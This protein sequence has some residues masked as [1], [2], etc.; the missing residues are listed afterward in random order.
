[1]RLALLLLAALLA[2]SAAGAAAEAGTDPLG[3]LLQL[4]ARRQHARVSFTEVHQFAMLERPLRSSGELLYD[5]PDRLEKR[6]LEPR[7]ETLRVAHGMLSIERGQRTRMLALRDYPQA[8][9]FIE[10]I[11]ATLAGDRAA[12]ERYFS[13]TFRGSLADWTLELQP[14][15]AA[16]ARTVQQVRISGARDD[17]RTVEIRQNDGDRSLLTIGAPLNP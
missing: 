13:V 5:A 1:M 17:I 2:S 12:L 15:D 6:T 9:P 16:L 11:R 3:E 8:I 7:P 14:R 4:L 10:S